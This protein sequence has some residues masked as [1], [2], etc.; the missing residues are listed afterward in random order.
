MVLK[1]LNA[2]L[3]GAACVYPRI[4]AFICFAACYNFADP[5]LAAMLKPLK[6]LLEATG[7]GD[8]IFT[9]ITEPFLVQLKA[10]FVAAFFVLCPT[11][12]CNCTDS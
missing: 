10:A 12:A 3:Y 11:F 2:Q 7:R 8:V 1:R 6:L 9:G 4:L 5:I